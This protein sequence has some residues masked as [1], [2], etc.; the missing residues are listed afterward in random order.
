MEKRFSRYSV[1]ESLAR[2][3]IKTF[4]GKHRA[5]GTVYQGG[6]H[7]PLIV[8]GPMVE[9]PGRE[10]DTLVH[11]VDLYATI[12]EMGGVDMQTKTCRHPRLDSISLVPHLT[13][14]DT[15]PVRD[16]VY[17]EIFIGAPHKH[18]AAAIRNAQYKLVADFWIGRYWEYEL[19]DLHADPLER[20]NLLCSGAGSPEVEA[21]FES[22]LAEMRRLRSGQ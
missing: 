5:K 7:V 14:P 8:A 4:T 18:G 11:T 20:H 9:Q 3:A 17:T 1:R 12:L 19:F 13:D 2:C 16:T 15:A 21:A 22:L 6:V 10:C